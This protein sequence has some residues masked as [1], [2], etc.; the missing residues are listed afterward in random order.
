MYNAGGKWIV[1]LRNMIQKNKAQNKYTRETEEV[2][3]EL[4]AL[5]LYSVK[6]RWSTVAVL[7]YNW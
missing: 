2:I 5:H 7:H 6:E 3:H 4:Q 1:E